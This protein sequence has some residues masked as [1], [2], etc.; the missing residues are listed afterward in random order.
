MDASAAS[1]A[2]QNTRSAVIHRR[3][4]SPARTFTA[5]RARLSSKTSAAIAMAS[6]ATRGPGGQSKF[7]LAQR[8]LASHYEESA[9]SDVIAQGRPGGPPVSP[10][11]CPPP[12]YGEAIQVTIT[13]L[14]GEA[15]EQ[16]E[17][18]FGL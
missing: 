17:L 9:V 15:A 8:Y 1:M 4:I 12:Q 13:W 5:T 6:P 18:V 16:P 14:R 3:W 10:V 2:M 11:T 7:T